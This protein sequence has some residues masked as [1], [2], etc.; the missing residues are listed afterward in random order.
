MAAETKC[1]ATEEEKKKPKVIDEDKTDEAVYGIC[2]KIDGTCT[3]LVK[4]LRS[5]S[6][7]IGC[8]SFS[9]ADRPDNGRFDCY[10]DASNLLAAGNRVATT[11]KENLTGMAVMEIMGFA[12]RSGVV[13]NAIVIANSALTALGSHMPMSPKDV[14]SIVK[15]AQVITPLTQ[16]SGHASAI[17]ELIIRL[18]KEYQHLTNPSIARQ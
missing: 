17:N 9:I 2:I 18:S 5:P 1:V 14:E 13:R 6:D 7:I 11:A 15:L 4:E 8:E 3:L 16:S 12:I 10:M